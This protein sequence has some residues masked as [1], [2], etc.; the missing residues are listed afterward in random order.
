[1]IPKTILDF[2]KE[3]VD[4]THSLSNGAIVEKQENVS[5]IIDSLIEGS[6]IGPQQT[7]T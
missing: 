5:A 4:G 7:Y 6:Q 3:T 2:I 1:M